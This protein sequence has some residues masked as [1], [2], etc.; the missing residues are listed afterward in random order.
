MQQIV[1]QISGIPREINIGF[2]ITAFIMQGVEAG[3]YR[4]DG[5]P[6]NPGQHIVDLLYIALPNFEHD[7]R[8][9]AEQANTE[10]IREMFAAQNLILQVAGAA[11]RSQQES[12]EETVAA[13]APE[14]GSEEWKSRMKVQNVD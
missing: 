1:I 9:Y 2:D 6:L 12:A 7:W 8:W 11:I 4:P 5:Y 13:V 3:D 10:Q 14:V